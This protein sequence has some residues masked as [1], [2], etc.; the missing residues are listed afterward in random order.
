MSNTAVLILEKPSKC[1]GVSMTLHVAVNAV[2][3]YSPGHKFLDLLDHRLSTAR[4]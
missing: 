4:F 2:Q 1:E 3:H